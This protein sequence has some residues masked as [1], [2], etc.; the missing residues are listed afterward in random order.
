MPPF[1][2]KYRFDPEIERQI[3][4]ER[5]KKVE[6]ARRKTIVDN[7]NQYCRINR[8]NQLCTDLNPDDFKTYETANGKIEAER[9]KKEMETKQRSEQFAK[10][11]AEKILE[12]QSKY[13]ISEKYCRNK[14]HPLCVEAEKLKRVSR[15]TSGYSKVYSALE[16]MPIDLISKQQLCAKDIT[17]KDINDIFKQMMDKP[18]PAAQPAAPPAEPPAEPPPNSGGTRKK[19]SHKKHRS[20]RRNDKAPKRIR[21]KKRRSKKMN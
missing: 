8:G 14:D 19:R 9:K 15:D 10:G 12:D 17:Y 4:D 13:E 20:P 21:S 3:E 18:L 6:D 16:Q 11:F 1:T 5:L 7:V 2:F